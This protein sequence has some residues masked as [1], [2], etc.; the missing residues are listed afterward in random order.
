MSHTY[1]Y[2]SHNIAQTWILGIESP[3]SEF[4]TVDLEDLQQSIL[5]LKPTNR[6]EHTGGVRIEPGTDQE[7]ALLRWPVSVST[8]TGKPC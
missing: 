4:M 2:T 1:G 7:R 3:I 6:E 8:N 5:Y